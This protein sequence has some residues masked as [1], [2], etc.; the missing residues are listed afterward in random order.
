MSDI[1]LI[2]NYDT[3]SS[4]ITDDNGTLITTWIGL[5]DVCKEYLPGTI[6]ET[7]ETASEVSESETNIDE[8][9]RLKA[10]GFTADEIVKFRQSGVT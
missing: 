10:A 2:V 9:V 3:E 4:Y 5:Q 7:I 1:K 6:E 8:I